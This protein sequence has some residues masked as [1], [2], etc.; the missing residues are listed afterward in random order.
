MKMIIWSLLFLSATAFAEPRTP[1]LAQYMRQL[2]CTTSM[3]VDQLGRG[4]GK[5]EA[6]ASS[7]TA[8][9]PEQFIA[10][11]G[12]LPAEMAAPNRVARI[13]SLVNS[14]VLRLDL[15]ERSN[16]KASACLKLFHQHE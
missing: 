4:E 14:A 16:V 5:M 7:A 9:V 15:C 13:A 1:A 8:C 6:V 12:G 11:Q 2:D 10:E 3:A